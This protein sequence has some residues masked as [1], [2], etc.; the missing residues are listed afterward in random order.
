MI[1]TLSFFDNLIFNALYS[2]P[3]YLQGL[4]TRSRFWV[5]LLARVQID[6]L[7]V[8]FVSRLRVRYGA[9]YFFARVGGSP[10][11][12]V[13]DHSGI[14]HVLARS[15]FLYGDAV[16]K[17]RGMSH[18]QPG[19]VT[20]SRGE[21]WEDRR[22]FNEAV[23]H[24]GQADH[25]LGGRFLEVI[26]RSVSEVHKEAGGRLYWKHFDELFEQIA[27]G[28]IFGVDAQK[29]RPLFDRLT[30]M[31]QESNRVFALRKSEHFDVFY[32]GIR[33]QL[34]IPVAG[35]LASLCPH[36]PSSEKTRA[37]NQIPHWMF[38]I[39]ET[40][41]INTARALAL[42]A[43]HPDQ[44]ERARKELEGGGDI[45]AQRIHDLRYLEGCVQEAMRLWPTTPFIAREALGE[46]VI[47]GSS[48]F[49]KTQV[50]ILN[51]FNHRDPET[52]VVANAF[53]PEQWLDGPPA[54]PFNHLS[55][56]PQVC[57]GK[58]LALFI[59]KAVLAALMQRGRYTLERPKLVPGRPLPA[60]FNHFRLSLRVDKRGGI[61]G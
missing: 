56:G 2:I 17:H 12:L 15:P 45:T 36:A 40:L 35:S 21:E 26:Q 43:S 20:I 37:E 25:P 27:A 60:M 9:K 4:F 51:T 52:S 49:P 32:E 54:L 48:I 30:R 46:E 41:A 5:G 28:I 33:S 11:L 23:L 3:S 39:R 7:A 22:R 10:A 29:G 16:S 44:E 61:N 34:A 18:F 50:L 19:A 8:R 55:G 47:E 13:L 53:H 31:M 58:D 59:A 14:Q 38:A 6:R 42:L 24:T 57:A 1:Q